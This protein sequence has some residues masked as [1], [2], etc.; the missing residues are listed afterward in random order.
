MFYIILAVGAILRLWGIGYGFPAIFNGDEPHIVNMA[1][2]FGSGDFNPHIFK[3]PTLWTYLLFFSYGGMYALGLLTGFWHTVEEFGQFFVWNPT[4][5]YLIGRLLSAGASC[6]AVW[7]VWKMTREAGMDKKTAWA[8]AFLAVSPVVVY[9]AHS[10]KPDS[11]LLFFSAL[12]WWMAVRWQK[13]GRMRDIGLCGLFIGLACSC[14]YTALP[15]VMLIPAMGIYNVFVGHLKYRQFLK[16]TAIGF[17]CACAGFAITSP[18][19]IINFSAVIQDFKDLSVHTIDP[20]IECARLCIIKRVFMVFSNFAGSKLIFLFSLSGFYF[21]W[22]ESKALACMFFT[23]IISVFA[24]LSVQNIQGCC[25]PRYSFSSFPALV[26][27]AH[28]ALDRFSRRITPFL[29]TTVNMIFVLLLLTAVFKVY[30]TNRKLSLTDTRT[31]AGDWI[32]P[33]IPQGSA[34]LMDHVDSAPGLIIERAQIIGLY[35]KALKINHPRRHY[36]KFM[37]AGHPCGGYKIYQIERTAEDVFSGQRHVRWSQAAR[38]TVD[39]SSGVRSALDAGV[40]YVIESS[41]GVNPDDFERYK[42]FFD[43]VHACGKEIAG[44]QPAEDKIAG[45]VL[46][47]FYL[48]KNVCGGKRRMMKR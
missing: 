17:F 2:S 33:N 39:I 24:A 25:V 31:L 3:Y 27:L 14:Q 36:Y 10:A 44:F 5:F 37:L 46:K 29:R 12:A 19:H 32:K 6:A 40:Q 21:M 42:L 7:A 4:P 22:K 8:S 26:F 43:E 45:P 1:V 13:N 47:I 23:A 41:F 11:L 15:L 9:E 38:D 35:N 20:R 34:I 16:I 30:A 48:D 18:F 28:F